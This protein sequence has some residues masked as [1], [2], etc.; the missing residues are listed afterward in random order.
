M[1]I[2]ARVPPISTPTR[3]E[4]LLDESILKILK[5]REIKLGFERLT[6]YTRKD[7]EHAKFTLLNVIMI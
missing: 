2:L 7:F 5:K 4:G 1:Q 6:N 3:M